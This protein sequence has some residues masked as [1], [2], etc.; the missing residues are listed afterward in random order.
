MKKEFEII[1]A[2][3]DLYFEGLSLRKVQLH[4]L[5]VYNYSVSVTTIWRWVVN[6][7]TQ[8]KIFLDAAFMPKFSTVWSVDEIFLIFNGKNHYCWNVI[9]NTSRFLIATLV[10]SKRSIRY[11]TQVFR[12]CEAKAGYPNIVLSDGW[13]GYGAAVNAGFSQIAYTLEEIFKREKIP[14]VSHITVEGLEGETNNNVV[15]RYHG[16]LRERYKVMRG[17]KSLK[18]ANQIVNAFY[19]HYNYVRP[20]QALGMT[21]AE[22]AWMS[23]GG[24]GIK[25]RLENQWK[26]ILLAMH[27]L[28]RYYRSKKW[29][30]AG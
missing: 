25:F 26:N 4:L 19:V 16:T 23:G 30:A 28:P 18:T 6:Y 5:N 9:D 1:G 14:R 15:E 24:K 29:L 2:A 21:P 12:E 3:L 22:Y 8:A 17:F 7:G 11:A 10:S 13:N 27:Y 20:H